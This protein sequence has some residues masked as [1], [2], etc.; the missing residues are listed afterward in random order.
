MSSPRRKAFNQDRIFGK[1][2][3]DA[4]LDLRIIGGEDQIALSADEGGAN[5]AAEFGA[6]G[7]ILQI[8]IR[9]AEAAGGSAG[10]VETRMEAARARDRSGRAERRHKWI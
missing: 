1:M 5:F 2:R 10:L 3:Q 7:N 6:D 9:R 4:Q 8:W